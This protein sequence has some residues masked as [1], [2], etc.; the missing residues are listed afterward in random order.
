MSRPTDKSFDVARQILQAT[1]VTGS[2]DTELLIARILD[3]A[4]P[5]HKCQL[6]DS[7]N[8]ALNSGDGSYRP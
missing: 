2:P 4:Y 6:P 5:P 1:G 3:D 7:I 8:E